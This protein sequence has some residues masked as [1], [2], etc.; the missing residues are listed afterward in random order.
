VLFAACRTGAVGTQPPELATIDECE[1]SPLGRVA[2]PAGPRTPPAMR[3]SAGCDPFRDFR[4]PSPVSDDPIDSVSSLHAGFAAADITPAPGLGLL[5]WGPEA[6]TGRGFRNRLKARA[7]VLEDEDGR[8][9]AFAVVD[10]DAVSTI[11]H[12]AVADL[13][14]TKTGGA[15]GADRLILSA[16][17]T[18]SGPGNFLTGWPLNL[19]GSNT[20]GF[21][22]VFVEWLA[23]RISDAV[24]RAYAGRAEARAAWSMR[25]VWGRTR[26]RSMDAYERNADPVSFPLTP[27]GPGPPA[28]LGDS[29]RAVNPRWSLL[30]VELRRNGRWEPAGTLNV[31]SI[32]GTVVPSGNDLYDSDIQGVLARELESRLGGIHL[33]ANGT[34]GDIS[35][36]WPEASR[37]PVPS[38]GYHSRPGGPRTAP[39]RFD[40][41]ENDDAVNARCLREALRFL[42][43]LGSDL[44]DEAVAIYR[45]LDGQLH[46]DFMIRRNFETVRLTGREMTSDSLCNRPQA[47]TALAAGGVDGPSRFKDW[48][49]FGTWSL[50]IEWGGGAIDAGREDCQAPKHV[51]LP[52]LQSS[53]PGALQFPEQTQFAVV[54]IGDMWVATVPGEAT[55]EAGR[56]MMAAVREGAARTL[57]SSTDDVSPDRITLVGLANGYLNYVTTADE[58]EAQRYE[59]ASTLYGRWSAR[60]MAR[61]L[62]ELA[63]GME[64]PTTEPVGEILVRPGPNENH[65]AGPTLERGPAS[66]L[67]GRVRRMC[68]PD[69][70]TVTWIDS[71]PGAFQPADGLMVRFEHADSGTEVVDHHTSVE[72][73]ARDTADEGQWWTARWRPPAPLPV[74]S[75]VDIRFLRWNR[76]VTCRVGT[77]P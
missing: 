15:I 26:N 50:G 7:M 6:Q 20:P 23:D 10:L 37:C 57:G 42:G 47:G 41:V 3:Y 61:R 27:P 39:P 53:P 51:L 74:Q 28:G 14:H 65:L 62:R 68:R 44:A 29:L 52:G 16:T 77:A 36:T 54:R 22:N 17:H 38:M 63:A 59:G 55:T 46:T 73:E 34:E 72:V 11:L 4:L 48:K 45:G 35:P 21:D 24:S 30:R 67:D 71:V 40:W 13:V 25:N 76:D 70:V 64:S 5:G 69:L 66:F 43:Q 33:V 1:S 32:H 2:R 58:Y 56:E 18:H 49:A 75:R 8:S 9:M 60:F 12:R 19:I 31:F